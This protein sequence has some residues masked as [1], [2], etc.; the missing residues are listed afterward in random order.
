MLRL[1]IAGGRDFIDYQYMLES[2]KLY[3]RLGDITNV[4]CGMARGAD[5]MG[6]RWAKDHDIPVIEY[7]ADWDRH[8]RSAGYKR[9]LQMGRCGHELVAFWDGESRGTRHMI[10]IMEEFG[11]PTLIV[12]Y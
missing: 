10:D 5:M 12:R 7:P 11:K 6:R 4:V 8:G 9:N 1:I 2:M 3:P